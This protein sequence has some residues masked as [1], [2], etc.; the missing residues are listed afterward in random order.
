M[1]R[2]NAGNTAVIDGP[3]AAS[4]ASAA[5][6]FRTPPEGRRPRQRNVPDD[7]DEF[8][9]ALTRRIY[10]FINAW[11]GCPELLC[12]RNRGCMAPDNHCANVGPPSAEE[13]ER[14]WPRVQAEIYNALKEHM[15]AQGAG[16]E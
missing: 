3:R 14:D 5:R 11:H 2:A 15:A 6:A 16:E 12:A 9:D 7:A 4:S 13:M 10:M 1:P 8:R